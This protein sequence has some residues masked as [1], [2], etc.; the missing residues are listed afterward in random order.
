MFRILSYKYASQSLFVQ[1]S[2]WK[3]QII[4]IKLIVV[5]TIILQSP[6]AVIIILNS[7]YGD[8]PQKIPDNQ[9]KLHHPLFWSTSEGRSQGVR[10]SR[11]G[12]W[13]RDDTSRMTETVHVRICE[14]LGV[15][16]PRATR[17]EN[18][19]TAYFDPVSQ[20]KYRP[21]QRN[22]FRRPFNWLFQSLKDRFLMSGY[23]GI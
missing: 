10:Q 13:R 19:T 4:V 8:V 22:I 3:W 7:S 15:K 11:I 9:E 12:F 20:V 1:W 2:W 5:L 23:R 6:T 14:G 18:R 17:P 16:F 21:G